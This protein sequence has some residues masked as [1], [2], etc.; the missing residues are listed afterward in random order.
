MQQAV[1]KARDKY[2]GAESLEGAVLASDGFFP[3]RDA[4]DAAAE[5]GIVAFAQ[6]GGSVNDFDV[7]EA[8]NELNCAMVFTQE[9]CF[10][11]H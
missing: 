5:A 4:I 9:R 11:H 1:I 2:T 6:P 10:S 8:C 3:F 7:I